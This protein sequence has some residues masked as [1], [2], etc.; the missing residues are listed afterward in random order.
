MMW[1]LASRGLGL[2]RQ[3]GRGVPRRTSRVPGAPEW[4][5]HEDMTRETSESLLL[6]AR[7]RFKPYPAY[8]DSGVEWL[9]EIPAHWEVQRT[10]HVARLRSGHTPSRQH[11]EYWVHC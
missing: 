3:E 6:P 2:G 1:A 5:D 7:H 8:Q 4:T 10:K 11:P 9:G